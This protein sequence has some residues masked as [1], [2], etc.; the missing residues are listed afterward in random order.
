[1]L[2]NATTSNDIKTETESETT[3]TAPS[4]VP[5]LEQTTEVKSEGAATVASPKLPNS[6]LNIEQK[7]TPHL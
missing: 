1:V 7:V 4:S 5:H 3:G 6:P 2:N